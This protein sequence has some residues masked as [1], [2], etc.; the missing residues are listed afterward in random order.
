MW[1]YRPPGPNGSWA[2]GGS[3]YCEAR[4]TTTKPGQE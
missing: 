2:A 4:T 3:L 1:S